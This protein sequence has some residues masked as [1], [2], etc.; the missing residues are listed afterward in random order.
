MDFSGTT[1]LVIGD[2]MLD[3]YIS[4]T[5]S[6]ISPEAPVPVVNMR[7]SWYVPGG[8]ANVARGL[9]RLGCNAR[10]I[11]LVGADAAGD[12][13]RKEIMAE[14][15]TSGLVTSRTRPTIR[16]TRIIAHGQQL[17][18][19]DEE[20]ANKP[21][22]EERTALRLNFEEMLPDCA[23]IILSDYAKGVLLRDSAGRSL[24][25]DVMRA[26]GEAGIPVLVDPKGTDWDRYA[27]AQCVTPN[28]AEFVKIC[29][30]TP[31]F[32]ATNVKLEEDSRARLLLADRI[33]E[34]FSLE[35][36]L[37]TRG[38]RGMSLFT[39]GK[40]PTRI[41]A[42]PREV[43]DVSGAGDT[44]IATMAACVARGLSWPES[45]MIA[46]TAAGIAVGKMG[47][48]PVNVAELNQALRAGNDNPKLYSRAEIVEKVADWR[49]QGQNIVFTNGCFDVLHPGHVELLRQSAALGDRLIVGLNSDLSVKRLKGE[50]RPLQDERSRA[51]LLSAL[52]AVDAV[53]IFSEDTPEELI[54]A[55][56][57]DFLVKGGDYTL[58][59]VVGADFVRE[60]GGEVRLVDLVDGHSTTGIVRRMRA[61]ES[62]R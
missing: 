50:S 4:G 40:K 57:P 34:K 46:N 18:R 25:P 43:A 37:L 2:V 9:A 28:M 20:M 51:L 17:L 54:H 49:R 26:A 15:V 30:A 16:K 14:G 48:A 53:V 24:C 8:A 22:L 7:Q 62:C 55:I 56:R 35:R 19:L 27:G 61:E 31:G 1:I 44:V 33:C 21:D 39:P 58:D 29:E 38:A 11:G 32:A 12:T 60:Y 5:A 23:A 45:A 36:I 59:K 47:T 13:L 10:L 6:R 42:M 41:R 52:Q 3:H